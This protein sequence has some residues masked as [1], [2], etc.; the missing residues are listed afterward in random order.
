MKGRQGRS[1]LLDMFV[2]SMI[3]MTSVKAAD[4]L[5]A[6]V[7]SMRTDFFSKERWGLSYFNYMNGPTLQQ[8]EGGSINHYLTLK[9]KLNSD[10]YLSGIFQPDTNFQNGKSSFTMGDSYLQ[11]GYPT[12][13]KYEGGKVFGQVRYFLPMSESSR[14]AK[15]AGILST[16]IYAELETGPWQFTYIFIPKLYLNTK[17]VDGQR[18]F[19]HG[20]WIQSSYK[21]SNTFVLDFALY[22]MWTYS[23]NVAADFDNLLAYPGFTMKF[24]NDLSLSPYLEVPL[25]KAEGKSTSVG[26]SL[27]YTL[28]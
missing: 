27:S 18:V 16:R 7:T 12:I 10:W 26:A 14:N 8:S 13:A 3:G 6:G 11:L 25:L 5:P 23:R 15:V 19:S 4:T 22:P 28:L 9:H 24:T 20:H 1:V 21:L 2:V 17:S